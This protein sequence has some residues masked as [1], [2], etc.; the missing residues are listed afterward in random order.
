MPHSG[1]LCVLSF[2]VFLHQQ[3]EAVDIPELP[4]AENLLFSHVTAEVKSEHEMPVPACTEDIHLT[5]H[6]VSNIS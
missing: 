4:K 1:L 3:R 2:P 6:L 5:S